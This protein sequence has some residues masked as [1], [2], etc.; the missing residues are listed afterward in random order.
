MRSTKELHSILQ[1]IAEETGGILKPEL[2]VAKAAADDHPLHSYFEWND[3]VAAHSHRVSQARA[4]I[5]SVKVSVT[6]EHRTVETVFYT[7]NPEAEKSE[8]GYV[9]LPRLQTDAELAARALTAE[10]ARVVAALERA[11]G[12]AIALGVESQVDDLLDRL[13]S[14]SSELRIAE[15]A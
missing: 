13:R 10:F 1:E 7:K 11:R 4:L 3:S 6:V 14:L 15:A 9:A 5:R 2:V 12:M 8:S